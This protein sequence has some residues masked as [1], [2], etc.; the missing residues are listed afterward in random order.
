[1]VKTIN[2]ENRKIT[3]KEKHTHIHKHK[4]RMYPLDSS[5]S[6]SESMEIS[7]RFSS[8]TT[9]TYSIFNSTTTKW[10]EEKQNQKIWQDLYVA[11]QNTKLITWEGLER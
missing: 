4:H 1:M 7:N 11:P 5:Q 10:A 6:N 9:R 2:N 3:N 8:C